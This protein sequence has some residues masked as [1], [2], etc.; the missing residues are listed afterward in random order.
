MLS[1]RRVAGRSRREPWSFWTSSTSPLLDVTDQSYLRPT[2]TLRDASARIVSQASTTWGR[3]EM[4]AST[5]SPETV[6]AVDGIAEGTSE[7]IVD[8][9]VVGKRL[10][11]SVG[12][13]E[14][15][16]VGSAVGNVVG[17]KVGA[18]VGSLE[19][20]T[21]GTEEG[22]ADGSSEWA[23]LGA[24]EGIAECTRVGVSECRLVGLDVGDALGREVRRDD[25][26]A[27]GA[28][29][30]SGLGAVVGYSDGEIECRALGFSDGL[31]VGSQEGSWDSGSV[32]D[33]VGV[34]VGDVLES[35]VALRPSLATSSVVTRK[36]RPKSSPELSFSDSLITISFLPVFS[37]RRTS[38]VLSSRALPQALRVCTSTPFTKSIPASFELHL[39]QV[40]PA[41]VAERNVLA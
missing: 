1:A 21:V 32:G 10:A 37:D 23:T 38:S 41:L 29:D 7:G 35:V 12:M 6:G 14:W 11:C 33:D 36:S 40:V 18:K 20:T 22:P 4:I 34:A 39:I 3:F 8:G 28:E 5:S 13:P 24:P 30:S 19:G 25:G 15:C 27:E 9:L 17:P 2:P 31:A 16:Q 26:A